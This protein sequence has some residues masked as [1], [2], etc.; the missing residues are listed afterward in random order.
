L[1]RIVKLPENM[2]GIYEQVFDECIVEKISDYPESFV[3]KTNEIWLETQKKD[4]IKNYMAF[5][6]KFP[7]LAELTDKAKDRL[8][9]QKANPAVVKIEYQDTVRKINERYQWTTVFSETGGKAGFK[10]HSSAFYIRDS[11]GKLWG[12]GYQG[13]NGGWI[14]T[15]NVSVEVKKNGKYDYSY[16]CSVKGGTYHIKWMGEDDWGNHIE[17]EQNV[18]LKD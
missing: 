15:K 2:V 17:I 5:I 1:S 10:V 8:T 16:W 4:K 9:W 13:S 14:N 11:S 18:I 7:I 12:D 6:E 3:K